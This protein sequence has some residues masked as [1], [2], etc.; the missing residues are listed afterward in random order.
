MAVESRRKFQVRGSFV[1]VSCFAENANAKEERKKFQRE[2]L[3]EGREK[4][5]SKLCVFR[6][7]STP[8]IQGEGNKKLTRT[9]LA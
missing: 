9:Y 4:S 8:N 6:R 2:V 7:H 3:C 1:E 5:V